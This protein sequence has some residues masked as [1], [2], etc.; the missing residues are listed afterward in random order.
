LLQTKH[1]GCNS[2]CLC[3]AAKLSVCGC[4][5]QLAGGGTLTEVEVDLELTSRRQQQAGFIE[6]SFPTIAGANGN[7][8]IIHYRAQEG[9]CK[10][11][12]AEGHVLAAYVLLSI[13]PL[14]ITCQQGT[15]LII[16]WLPLLCLP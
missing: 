5:L 15:S 12:L 7:G 10:W 8:A 2:F 16:H 4:L 1:A 11:V 6:P 14:L 13:T 3:C 9:S